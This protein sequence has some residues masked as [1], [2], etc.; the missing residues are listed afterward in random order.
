M[1][2]LT[3]LGKALKTDISKDFK[4]KKSDDLDAQKNL[5]DYMKQR[6]TVKSLGKKVIYSRDYLTRLIKEAVH[7]C[8]SA[9]NSQSVRVVILNDKAHYKFWKMVK[10]VQKNHV[11]EHIY[12]SAV[13]RI[14]MCEEAF[15]TVLFFEDAQVVKAL[16]KQKPLQAAD[17]EVWS[18]QTSGMAQFAVWT[19]ISS[20]G[21]GA[22]LQHYNPMIDVETKALLNLPDSWD[23][24]AQLVFGSIQKT[25]DEKSYEDDDTLFRVFSE[26]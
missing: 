24:K 9:L 2:I 11:P 19:A 8:P 7:C 17:F 4:F 13:L 5:L 6:R 21:L 14:E 12:E 26:I 25:A 10:A 16:Q 15:G 3:K 23:L 18:E 20:V 1:T 22:A